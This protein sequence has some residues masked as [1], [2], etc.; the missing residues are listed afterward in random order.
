MTG[1]D[2]EKT[3]VPGAYRITPRLLSDARGTFHESYRLDELARVTGHDFRPVQTNYSSSV[4]NTLR[5]LHGTQLPPG[6]AKFVTCVRGAVFDVVVDLRLGSP[7]FG[8]HTATVLDAREGH[9]MFMV[10]GLFH[11]FVALTDDACVSYLCSTVF[12]P[13]T[14]INIAARDPELQLPWSRALTAEPV[15][16]EADAQAPTVREAIDRGLLPGYTDCLP[17]YGGSPGAAAGRDA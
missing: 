16:S 10:D 4:R 12:V 11:G 2:I 1:V 6:Q 9:A 3:A 7:T 13:G 5:G 14:Q 15:V 17:Y 8:K